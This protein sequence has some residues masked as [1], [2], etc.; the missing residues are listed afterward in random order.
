MITFKVCV[1]WLHLCDVSLSIS[2]Q[3]VDIRLDRTLLG[4]VF[5][6]LFNP[7]VVWSMNTPR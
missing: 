4:R 6:W 7:T 5:A 3:R 1:L 2:R